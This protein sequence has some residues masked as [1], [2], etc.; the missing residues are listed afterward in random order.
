MKQALRDLEQAERDNGFATLESVQD[1]EARNAL[2]NML[3]QL[4]TISGRLP[5]S[6]KSKRT[7]RFEI[8]AL[9][10]RFDAPDWW[11]TINPSDL[12]SPLAVHFAGVTID[13]GDDDEVFPQD[14]PA[15]QHVEFWQPKIPLLEP[16]SVSGCLMRSSSAFCSFVSIPL[17]TRAQTTPAA[18]S[19]KPEHTPLI[20]NTPIVAQCTSMASCG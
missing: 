8:H 18:F 1:A 2:K 17:N 20:L 15:H 12:H 13:F 9:I 4:N 16:D 19:A 6:N 3:H 10:Q 7:A 11:I 14:Y 5:L